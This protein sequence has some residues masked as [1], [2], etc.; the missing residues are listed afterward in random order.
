MIVSFVSFPLPS[1]RPDLDKTVRL[2]GSK[3]LSHRALI[4]AALAQG[5][6]RLRQVLS[7]EDTDRTRQALTAF[8]A[9]FQDDGDTLIVHGT[10]GRLHAPLAAID[11]G[12]SGTSLRLLSALAGLVPGPT[13]L[14]GTG[15]L[16]HRPLEP[17]LGA[18]AEMG[19]SSIWAPDHSTL[20]II[21]R[22]L[23][24]Q[25][26]LVIP[27]NISSQFISALLLIG[28]FVAGG[29]ELV[30]TGAPV[31]QP[32]LDMTRAV[33]A[34]AGITVQLT[35]TGFL[36]P[37]G[38][39]YQAFSL[40][41]EPDLSAACYFWAGAAATGGRVCIQGLEPALRR[42]KQA[43]GQGDSA[44]LELLERMGCLVN[45]T[46]SGL[47]VQGRPLSGIEVNM[48]HI[49]D[50]VPTLAA[51]AVLARGRTVI[52]GAEHLRYKESNRLT[53]LAEELRKTGADIEVLPDGLNITPP[54]V[55]Q[56]AVFDTHRDH[57]LAMSFAVLGLA[58]PGF[59]LLGPESVGKSFPGFWKAWSEFLR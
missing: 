46:P 5:E 31:S 4:V 30:V 48:S 18:L 41:I 56:P 43:M 55:L 21:G 54:E 37:A 1:A 12:M 38:Q 42:S 15:G 6:S 51:L 8:G 49:P 52:R 32:Y 53:A 20:T 57:R 34:T 27:G 23:T 13:S 22:P 14:T 24:R 11:L 39:H 50:Q 47:E 9:A 19:V 26:P 36:V 58:R 45:H 28:P 3:S 2:H 29:L 33:M 16:L 40:T 10:G 7:C 44:F 17:L 35:A 25:A 59:S